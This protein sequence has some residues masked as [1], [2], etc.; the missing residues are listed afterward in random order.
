LDAERDALAADLQ[1]ASARR[2][3]IVAAFRLRG[4]LG[5]F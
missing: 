4:L 1:A 3:I 5:E 2:E